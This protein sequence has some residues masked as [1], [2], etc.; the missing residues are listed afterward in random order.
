M[1]CTIQYAPII[2]PMKELILNNLILILKDLCRLCIMHS[3]YVCTH[4]PIHQL[5][6]ATK[7]G[8]KFN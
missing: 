6:P 1:L 2:Q 5:P 7:L 4:K 3:A 8:T